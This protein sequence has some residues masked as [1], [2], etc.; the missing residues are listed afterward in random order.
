MAAIQV[1]VSKAGGQAVLT[2]NIP[3]ANKRAVMETP[4]EHL[5]QLPTA[6]L[7]LAKIA[8]V[9]INVGSI[10][11]PDLFADVPEERLAA[12]RQ[13][14]VPL[15]RAFNNLRFRSATQVKPAVFPLSLMP[16]RLVPIP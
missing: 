14:G 15:A 1:A 6:N 8:D 2:L 7:L 10:E 11:D 12:F 9:F 4:I 16:N 3:K 5:E 13:A